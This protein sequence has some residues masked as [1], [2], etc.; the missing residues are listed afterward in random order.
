MR[1]LVAVALFSLTSFAHAQGGPWDGIYSC[2]L[3][4]GQQRFSQFVAINGQPDGQSVFTLPAVEDRAP[5]HGW[6]GGQITAGEFS[7]LTNF[8]RPFRFQGNNRAFSGFVEG[9]SGGILYT[10]T[11][12]CTR[13]F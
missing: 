11:G 6:G 4:I 3:T 5:F 8:G 10:A 13:V 12:G 1:N 7:G 9:V 2:T